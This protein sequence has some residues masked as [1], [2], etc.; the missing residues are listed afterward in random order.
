MKYTRGS[1][2]GKTDEIPPLRGQKDIPEGHEMCLYGKT[3]VI[4]GLLESLK[5]Q[6]ATDLIKKHGGR[7]TGSVSSRT[8]FLVVGQDA[9]TTKCDKVFSIDL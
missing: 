6:G 2:Y 7:I 4:S 5:R 8:T 9:G 1:V 3:F